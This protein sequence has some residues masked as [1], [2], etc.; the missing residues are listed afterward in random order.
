[1]PFLSDVVK[2]IHA[3]QGVSTPPNTITKDLDQYMDKPSIFG[4]S[5][6]DP[7]AESFLS[8][9][10][11]VSTVNRAVEVKSDKVAELPIVI[12]QKQGDE[13]IDVSDR[14]DLILFKKYNTL[15]TSFDFWQSTIGYLET[16][17]E[18]FWILNRNGGGFVTE[19]YPIPPPFID[20]IAD[21]EFKVKHY[22][23]TKDGKVLH[24]QP[25]DMF[26]IKYWNPSDPIRGLSPMNAAM[27]DIIL[28]LY[29]QT[30][31]KRTFEKGVT[32]SGILS[33]K[34]EMGEGEWNRMQKYVRDTYS[35]PDKYGK[36]MFL[37]GGLSWQQMA[38][39]NTKMQFMD[40]RLYTQSKI[41]EV[42]GVPPIFFMD[43]RDASVLSNADVQY[44]LLWETIKPMLVKIQQ[45]M[46][47]FFLP[48]VTN[49]PDL[50]F[51][52]ELKG[53]SA[54]QPDLTALGTRFATGFDK[55]AV[56]PNEIRV[57]VLGLKADNNPAMD[58]KYVPAGLIPIDDAGV[59][60]D[61]AKKPEKG[62]LSRLKG[63]GDMISVL[64]P[65][66]R[67]DMSDLRQKKLDGETNVWKA[68]G[69]S[70][71][72]RVALGI[73][74]DF[75]KELKKLLDAQAKEVVA[76]ARKN[77]QYSLERAVELMGIT[78]SENPV[79]SEYKYTASG[80]NFDYNEW[81]KTFEETGQ[82]AISASLVAAGK[83]LAE[84]LDEVFNAED[85]RAVKFVKTRSHE[86]AALVNDTTKEAVNNI[87]A[88]G[89]AE[90][91][92]VQE[93]ALKLEKYFLNNNAMRAE[94]IARTETVGASNKGRQEAMIQSPRVEERMWVTQRDK[95]VRDSHSH[96]DGVTAKLGEGYVGY[97]D[98]FSPDFPSSP[99]E[100]CYEIPYKVKK[101]K[102]T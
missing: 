79:G 45:L 10:E 76:N 7:N 85:V 42:Y 78:I 21:N 84:Q 66:D 22:D 65:D 32:P 17:G 8:I 99:N 23:F 56:S 58:L 37:T 88:K 87:V 89:I 12:E 92:T 47:E 11:T 30:S 54:L 31:S 53:V 25:E 40:Q 86:Y 33:T 29:A 19:M 83:E 36:I 9:Y 72:Q 80:V 38:L 63:M 73:A 2:N 34:E 50:R 75:A 59:A 60:V 5:N 24:I 68:I 70:S 6:P 27:N 71:I 3:A 90:E 93:L 100:R 91:L 46:T 64:V 61:D 101:K 96:L 52:F 95:N 81:V 62:L 77:K 28:D 48:M 69:A 44:R 39:D 4:S 20:I 1:M 15:Q 41:R 18:T 102:K 82:P 55:G 13:W 97:T 26:F 35:G 49:L 43:F 51:R 57:N 67:L 74:K 16:L 94:R 98:G 14:P